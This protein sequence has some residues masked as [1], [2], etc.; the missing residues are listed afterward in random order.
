MIM[1][2][3]IAAIDEN[4]V[5]GV[6]NTLPRNI[7]ADLQRFKSLTMGH[8]VLM[9]RKTFESIGR[10]LPGR[11]NIVLTKNTSRFY[12]GVQIQHDIESIV[13][14]YQFTDQQLYVIGGAEIYEAFLPY[15]D[16][17]ELTHVHQSV[18]GDTWF[19]DYVYDFVPHSRESYDGYSFV[20]YTPRESD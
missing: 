15:A 19:P 11:E 5:I 10:P 4:R 13:Y 16:A 8:T 2:I 6:N 18:E 1:I 9:G 17:L 14:K 20:S 3:L 7:S 12:D